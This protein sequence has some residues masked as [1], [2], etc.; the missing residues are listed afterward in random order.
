MPLQQRGQL[1]VVP[2]RE[3]VGA[4]IG[5]IV[6]NRLQVIALEP[7]HR[8]LGHAEL[9]RGLQARVAGDDLARWT[10][11][12]RLLPAEAT[13]ACGDV[14]NGLVIPPRVGRRAVQPGDF[15]GLD[16]RGS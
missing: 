11:D 13:N 2:V 1:G 3:L 16:R 8:D 12:D 6:G 7:P 15:N 10:G 4:G 9:L 5:Q 14:R